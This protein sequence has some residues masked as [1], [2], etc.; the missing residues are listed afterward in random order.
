MTQ[1]FNLSQLAN[2]LNTSGQLDATDGLTGVLPTSNLPTIPTT[3]GGTGLTTVG[4]NGQVL[5]SNGTTL[6]WV[7]FASGQLQYALFASS[8]TW[9]C[10]SGVTRVLAYVVSGGS[11]GV[12]VDA[13]FIRS[14]NQGTYAFGIYTVTPST[15][16][17]ITV[18]AGGAGVQ[19]SSTATS[20][21]GTS[22]FSS[23][24]SVSGASATL[25]SSGSYT[26]GGNVITGSPFAIS[27][28]GLNAAVYLTGASQR[29]QTQAGIAWSPSG[30]FMAGAS[31]DTGSGATKY[32]GVGGA[33]LLQY[34]G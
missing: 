1:A 21:G 24:L 29:K 25:T 13:G 20:T 34:V 9:T 10:P 27:R 8:G 17:A 14:G 30:G 23:F 7:S 5:Q 19:S 12:T 22:S 15:G 11:G 2:N 28:T 18:G 33:V 4:T 6:S 26:S 32:G 16:Y 31:G 3:K